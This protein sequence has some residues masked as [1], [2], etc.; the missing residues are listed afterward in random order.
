MVV[1]WKQN[2]FK[3]SVNYVRLALTL[4]YSRMY[5]ISVEMFYLFPT[6]M[7]RVNVSVNLI[8]LQVENK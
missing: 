7:L 3:L 6:S 1:S 8:K 2:I 5:Q 4:S